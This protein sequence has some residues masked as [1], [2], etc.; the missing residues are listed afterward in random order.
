MRYSIWFSN[1]DEHW[2]LGH[3]KDIGT[4]NWIFAGPS[5]DVEWPGDN[6][7]PWKY[8]L[9][10]NDTSNVKFAMKIICKLQA[11]SPKPPY[12]KVYCIV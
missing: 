5:Q 12:I 2:C 9:Q 10:D 8:N 11:F 4:S 3:K 7:F 1:V 6:S